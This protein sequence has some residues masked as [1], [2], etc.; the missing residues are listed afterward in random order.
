MLRLD[1]VANPE[2]AISDL[3]GGKGGGGALTALE[4]TRSSHAQ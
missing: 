2:M 3:G 1:V 4:G